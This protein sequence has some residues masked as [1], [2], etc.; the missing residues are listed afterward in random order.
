MLYVT[1]D[2]EEAMTLGDRIAVMRDGRVEQVAP[3]L[4]V[5]RRPATAF[6]AGFVGSPAMN[7]LAMDVQ[8]EPGAVRAVAPDLSLRLAP[9]PLPPTARVLLGIRPRDLAL[10]PPEG[11][12]ARARVEVAQALGSEVLVHLA[13]RDGGEADL[14]ALVAPDAAPAVGAIVGLRFR[15]DRLHL[16]DG[17]RGERIA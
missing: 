17:E 12:D 15:P 9:F 14:R 5:Y 7:L 13:L 10:A 4:E 11:A 6:V 2:Q 16:F 3:P 1:H 8:S